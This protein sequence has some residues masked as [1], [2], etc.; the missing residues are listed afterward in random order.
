MKLSFKSTL[1]ALAASASLLAGPLPEARAHNYGHSTLSDASAL[2]M[3]PIAVS[4][5]APSVL[6]I[7]GA[8]F[9]VVAVEAASNGTVW[10]LERASDGVQTSVTVSGAVAGGASLAVGAAVVVT[11]VSAGWILSAAGQVI[12]FVPNEIGRALMHHERVTR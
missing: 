7:G 10:V 3:L 9:T 8:A 6:L 11:A 12:A 4:V 2:S 1:L 5:A